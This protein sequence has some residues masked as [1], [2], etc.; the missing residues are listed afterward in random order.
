MLEG[1]TW[2][3]SMTVVGGGIGMLIQ[4]VRLQMRMDFMQTQVNELKKEQAE[5]VVFR[6]ETEKAV[7]RIESNIEHMKEMLDQRLPRPAR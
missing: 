7:T 6:R 3:N 4:H 1:W 5:N 2:A